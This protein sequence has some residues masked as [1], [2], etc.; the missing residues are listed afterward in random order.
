MHAL[1][2][3]VHGAGIVLAQ[4]PITAG[5]D[6]AE[7]E[8]AVAPVLLDRLDW[9]DRVLT[10][11]ALVCQRALCQQMR[12]A[13][14][15][16]LLMVKDNEPTLARDMRWLFDIPSGR[17]APLTLNDERVARTVE[18]EHG[19]T[20]DTRHLIATTDLVGYSDWP[21]LA[22]VFRLEWWWH[23]HGVEKHADHYGVTSLTPDRSGPERLLELKRAHWQIEPGLHDAKDVTLG[24][25]RSL[26]HVGMDPS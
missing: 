15:D 7:A 25:N 18:R 22:Q 4:E 13:G 21:G 5:V 17:A 2:A 11:D 3:L 23:A 16:D 26:V 8:Q 1:A 9:I 20:N 12:A 14:G 6:T 24:E 19:R 10:G